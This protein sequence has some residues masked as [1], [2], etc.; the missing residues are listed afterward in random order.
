M[1]KQDVIEHFGSQRA[2]AEALDISEQAV[3]AW[4]DEIPEGRQ[5][6]IQIITGGKLVAKPQ[7]KERRTG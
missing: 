3:S 4:E 1:R 5:F 2:I 7:P 6:Q